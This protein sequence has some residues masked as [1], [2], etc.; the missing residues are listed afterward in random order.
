M[1]RSLVADGYREVLTTVIADG[2]VDSCILGLKSIGAWTQKFP[3]GFASIFYGGFSGRD[4]LNALIT[5]SAICYPN[6]QAQY[7]EDGDSLQYFFGYMK[8]LL[9]IFEY[10]KRHQMCVIH[11]IDQSVD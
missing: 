3:E 6:D 7:G 2:Q 4:V 10:A 5:A 11:T 9:T 8:M 1:H